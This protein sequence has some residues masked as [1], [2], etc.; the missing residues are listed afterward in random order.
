M[1]TL[2]FYT[3][4]TQSRRRRKE[5]SRPGRTCTQGTPQSVPQTRVRTKEASVSLALL[6]NDTLVLLEGWGLTREGQRVCCTSR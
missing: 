6:L 5:R 1:V 4:H 3:S 2:G